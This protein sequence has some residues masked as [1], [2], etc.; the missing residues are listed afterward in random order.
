MAQIT[1][2]ICNREKYDEKTEDF[3]VLCLANA[4]RHL[5]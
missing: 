2:L 5:D 1:V 3:N 4:E